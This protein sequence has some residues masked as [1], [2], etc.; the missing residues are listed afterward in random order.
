MGSRASQAAR[1]LHFNMVLCTQRMWKESKKSSQPAAGAAGSQIIGALLR[2]GRM[3][4]V[5]CHDTYH[6]FSFCVESIHIQFYINAFYFSNVP[7]GFTLH[8]HTRLCSALY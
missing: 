6:T 1:Q 3:H 8:K 2:P 4:L 5:H 7:F